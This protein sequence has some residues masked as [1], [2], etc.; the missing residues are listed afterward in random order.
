M[1]LGEWIGIYL[2][3]S[4]KRISPIIKMDFDLRGAWESMII[5]I[6]QSADG[7]GGGGWIVCH[8]NWVNWKGGYLTNGE[9]RKNDFREYELDNICYIFSLMINI[10]CE[11]DWGGGGG[12]FIPSGHHLIGKLFNQEMGS[13]DGWWWN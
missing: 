6:M 3:P 4:P 10:N 7:G 5:V 8:L 9:G 13:K 12:G 1:L 11:S 2:P